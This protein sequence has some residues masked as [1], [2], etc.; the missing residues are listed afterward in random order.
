MVSGMLL[1]YSVY[2]QMFADQ[3]PI[4]QLCI[5]Y[6]NQIVCNLLP[7]HALHSIFKDPY[8]YQFQIRI[9]LSISYFFSWCCPDCFTL[10]ACSIPFTIFN[11]LQQKEGESALRLELIRSFCAKIKDCT[12]SNFSFSLRTSVC[13]SWLPFKLTF[14]LYLLKSQRNKNSWLLSFIWSVGSLG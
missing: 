11:F 9:P 7:L 14:Y 13:L 12:T 1:F 10:Q 8:L 2:L 6:L 3:Q 4:S 5:L